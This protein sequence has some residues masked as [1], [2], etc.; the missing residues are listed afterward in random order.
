M[1]DT[2]SSNSSHITVLLADDHGIVLEGLASLIGRQS[3][4][5][6]VGQ[7]VDG[8]EAVS[9]WLR[10][11]PSITLVDLRMPVL[12]GVSVIET[13]LQHDSDARIV[14]L[15]TFDS[16]SDLSRA[17]KAGAKGYLLK[18]TTREELLACIRRVHSGETWIQP[19]LV[20]KLVEGMKTQALSNREVEVI[21]LLAKGNSNKQIARGLSISE[22]T[23]K[24]HLHNI[25]AKL[26]V[27]SRTEALAVANQRGI[28][29]L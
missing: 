11:R 12:D 3:D 8:E 25:F 4:M 27:L 21:T 23:V 20:P 14:V 28:V 10:Y 24:A 29:Q 19:S 18:D 7:A 5:Q 9:L 2:N 22:T 26:N 6:V 1:T 13:L 15:T 16:D 17:I